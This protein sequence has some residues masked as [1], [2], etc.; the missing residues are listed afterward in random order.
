MRTRL[1]AKEKRY[2]Q[3]ARV[4]RVASTEKNGRPHEAPFCPAYDERRRTMYVAADRDGH[5][6]RNLRARP[7]AAILCDDYKEDWNRLRGVVVQARARTISRG[8]ELERARRLLSRKFRQYR[9]M[10]ID[11]VL[12]LRLERVTSSWGL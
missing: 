5:G 9:N 6:A 12:G 3:R 4:C 1:T 10:E 7:R 8:P 2:L 11:Y